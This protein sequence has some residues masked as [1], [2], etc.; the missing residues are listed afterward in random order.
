[1]P[2][3]ELTKL[4]YLVHNEDI[5]NSSRTAVIDMLGV[6][7]NC[8]ASIDHHMEIVSSYGTNSKVT[9]ADRDFSISQT[10][11]LNSIR[12]NAMKALKEEFEADEKYWCIAKHSFAIAQFAEEVWHAD[13][14][15]TKFYNLFIEAN[16][17]LMATLSKWLGMPD[18]VMCARCF[19][20]ML[21]EEL[22]KKKTA[23][24]IKE[25]PANKER[26]I[27][28]SGELEE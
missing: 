25:E 23:D 19:N 16:G 14:T 6:I 3:E 1:M 24:T 8:I 27:E 7:K 10:S 18:I 5:S 11:I 4:E 2:K 22:D 26:L 28:V 20:D 12:R 13:M 21:K 17:V 15:N 9:L